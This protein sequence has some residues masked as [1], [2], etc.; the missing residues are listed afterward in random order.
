MAEQAVQENESQVM[1]H[2]W[3]DEYD[4]AP[5]T[6][7]PIPDYLKKNYW[8]AYLHPRSVAIFE[9]QWIINSILWGHYDRLRNSAL[10]ELGA[11]ISGRTLQVAC[12]YGDLTPELA[13]RQLP[14]ARLDGVDVA[15]KQLKNLCRQM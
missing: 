9:H 12:V 11:E 7:P 4:E 3:Q 1:S 13:Q 5:T 6:G 2:S 15:P 10:D 8:W 14:G